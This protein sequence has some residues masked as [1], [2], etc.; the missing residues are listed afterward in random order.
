MIPMNITFHNSYANKGGSVREEGGTISIVGL[1]I[2]CNDFLG[3]RWFVMKKGLE[4]DDASP[5]ET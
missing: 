1:N 3:E 2:L 5:L 4:G